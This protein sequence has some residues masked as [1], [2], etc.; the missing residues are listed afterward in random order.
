M[1]G[2]ATGSAFIVYSKNNVFFCKSQG[3]GKVS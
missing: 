1:I 3:D 2:D